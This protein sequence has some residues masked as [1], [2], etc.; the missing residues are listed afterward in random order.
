MQRKH[1]VGDSES[2][3]RVIERSQQNA[4]IIRVG[5]VEQTIKS[6]KRFRAGFIRRPDIRHAPEYRCD[7]AQMRWI[8]LHEFDEAAERVLILGRIAG[9]ARRGRRGMRGDRFIEGRAS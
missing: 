8:L 7:L 6:S 1:R 5:R 3:R 4:G 2:Q 9:A